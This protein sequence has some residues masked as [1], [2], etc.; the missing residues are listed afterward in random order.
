HKG[1][2][3]FY[4]KSVSK[5]FFQ[6]RKLETRVIDII[7]EGRNITLE[8]SH[9]I[10]GTGTIIFFFSEELLEQTNDKDIQEILLETLGD[11][12]HQYVVLDPQS[13]LYHL[14]S[15]NHSSDPNL[16]ARMRREDAEMQGY[17]ASE[18]CFK[19]MLYIPQLSVEKALEREWA[20]RLRDYEP[21]DNGSK[22]QALLTN[23]G[24]TVLQSW[25]L[26][27]VG[28]DYAFYLSNSRRIG[29]FAIPTGKIIITTALFDSLANAD[30][31]EALL[32]YAVAHIEQRHSLK[33]YFSCLQDEEY[34]IA[35]KNLA[36][37][38][39]FLAGP[40]SGLVSGALSAALPDAACN[41]QSLGGYQNVYKQ[42]ADSM[43]AL[44]FKAHGKDKGAI[45][46]LIKKLQFNDLSERLHPDQRLT[47]ANEDS[48]NERLKRVKNSRLMYFG[49]DM[50]F[51]LKRNKQPPVQLDLIG[52]RFYKK[53]NTL[54]A[55]IDEKNLLQLN[56]NTDGE[57]ITK[58]L[59]KDKNGNHH[60]NLNDQFVTEDVWGAY[61]TFETSSPQEPK[62]LQGIEKVVLSLAPTKGPVDRESSDPGDKMIK[63]AG[64][65]LNEQIQRQYVFVPGT[66][67]W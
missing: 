16:S 41:P 8:L 26:K 58:L 43:A 50:N 11:E 40:A 62:V 12:N 38:A 27:R 65:T 44:Y 60:F 6:D 18:F 23:V 37:A 20:K 49:K 47:G 24:Q 9:S 46:S 33:E 21:I 42:E 56:Q 52:Q 66:I 67:E 39:G 51:V 59:V 45:L 34:A 29:A 31:L 2:E 10:L 14:W 55:Y 57:Q 53:E 63:G 5:I 61:L 4:E 15:C 28:Y 1:I 35:M 64:D 22:K 13:K 30:E 7:I 54:L 3:Y 25:P 19:K 36:A 32:V 17:R 48:F